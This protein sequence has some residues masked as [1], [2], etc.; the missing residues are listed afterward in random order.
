MDRRMQSTST[1]FLPSALPPS[2]ETRCRSDHVSHRCE[3]EDTAA[4][5]HAGDEP[6]LCVCARALLVCTRIQ[7][8]RRR[9]S[10]ALVRL[11]EQTGFG[12]QP[13]TVDAALIFEISQPKGGPAMTRRGCLEC[14]CDRL[15][16][17]G[18]RA[19]TRLGRGND[20]VNVGSL[21]HKCQRAHPPVGE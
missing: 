16:A 18:V 2:G 6:F 4:C 13:S 9:F 11:L 10:K 7:E 14:R 17:P 15:A 21:G 1:R 3:V 8:T 12:F 19:M 5:A 20:K